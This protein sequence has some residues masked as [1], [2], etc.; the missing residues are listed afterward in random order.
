MQRRKN[1]RTPSSASDDD[2]HQS[3]CG[4]R[5][6]PSPVQL[7]C[8][9]TTS[10]T[11][12][13]GAHGAMETGEQ[14]RRKRDVHVTPLRRACGRQGTQTRP[15]H[16]PVCGRSRFWLALTQQ[17]PRP[18]SLLCRAGLCSKKHETYIPRAAVLLL[19]TG[20]PIRG[21]RRVCL[22]ASLEIPVL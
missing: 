3:I 8:M 10:W 1:N 11:G 16:R 22:P 5:R 14:R 20:L 9:P 19:H 4:F 17:A 2:Q 13:R 18:D 15:P 21:S 7:R 12:L 6:P